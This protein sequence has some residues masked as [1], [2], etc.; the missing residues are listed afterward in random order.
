MTGD[1]FICSIFRSS[2]KQEMYLYVK[3]GTDLGE[4]PEPL[5]KQFGEPALV[6][7]LLLHGE[8]KL[9]RADVATVI[10]KIAEQGF[11]LQMPPAEGWQVAPPGQDA[12]D[13]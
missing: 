7:D 10:N 1:R 13:A 8:R 2:K 3:K 9:A 6:M 11:Y 4:L 5:L 12:S